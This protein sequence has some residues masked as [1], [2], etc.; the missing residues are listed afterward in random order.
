MQSLFKLRAHSKVKLYQV[1]FKG[2]TVKC[3]IKFW[4]IGDISDQLFGDDLAR[5]NLWQ[6]ILE[7]LIS[8]PN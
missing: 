7:H 4:N 5:Y 6:E 2:N 8:K 3:A 1:T